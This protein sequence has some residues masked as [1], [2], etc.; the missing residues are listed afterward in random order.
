LLKKGKRKEKLLKICKILHKILIITGLGFIL[1]IRKGR[2]CI[3]PVLLE[4]LQD[5]KEFHLDEEFAGG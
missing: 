4:S 2:N 1:Q 3:F 5:I